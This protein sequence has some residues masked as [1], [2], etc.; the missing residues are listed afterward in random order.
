MLGLEWSMSRSEQ[1]HHRER[2]PRGATRSAQF[3]KLF[4]KENN[5]GRLVL[6]SILAAISIG[7][8]PAMAQDAFPTKP[9]KIINPTPVGS[10]P[11]VLARLVGEQL[12]DLWRQPVIVENRPGGGGSIAARAVASSSPDGYTLLGGASSTFTILPAEKNALPFDVNRD[13]AQIGLIQRG[14]LFLAVPSRLGVASLPELIAL[15]KSRP[16]EIVI[17]TNGTGS[18]PHFAALALARMGNIP[19]TIA[20]YAT[21]GTAAVI[22]DMLGGRVHATIDALA[23]LRGTLQS[24][25]IKLIAVMS[26][27]RDPFLPG[28]PTVAETVPGLT[29]VGWMSLAAP[30]GT[31]VHIVQRLNEGLRHVLQMPSI[32]QR[33]DEL[34]AQVKIMTPAETKAFVEIEQKLWWPIVKEAG[35]E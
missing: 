32:N 1:R 4:L 35:I 28:L 24:G 12:T 27:E 19:I 29:A 26:P 9:I 21:G 22:T 7:I 16:H 14:A 2:G 23:G 5:M 6:T 33:F 17:G 8:A 18:F 30:A 31:P 20:P 11:D 15:A 10:A 13:F 3:Q 34:G 25:D